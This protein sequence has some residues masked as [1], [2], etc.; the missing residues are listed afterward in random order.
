MKTFLI[1]HEAE[2]RN[3]T[4]NL[5][6]DIVLDSR[7][8]LQWSY[9]IARGM[10]YLCRKHIMHGDLAA[11]NVLIGRGKLYHFLNQTNKNQYIFH[12][13]YIRVISMNA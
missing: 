10:K 5:V 3:A 1:K 8:L 4:N 9:D 13:K 11:R 2:F 7:L 12:D 6:N